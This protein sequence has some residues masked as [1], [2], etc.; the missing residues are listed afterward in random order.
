[1][2]GKAPH[3]EGY[4]EIYA[5]GETENSLL[6]FETYMKDSFSN[7]IAKVKASLP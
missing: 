7:D 4:A 1:M 6:A 3:D 5:R 2:N